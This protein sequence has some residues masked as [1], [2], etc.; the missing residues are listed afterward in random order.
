M[1][2]RAVKFVVTSQISSQEDRI[3]LVDF[4]NNTHA[5]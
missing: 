1:R 5:E 3:G 2:H 4:D